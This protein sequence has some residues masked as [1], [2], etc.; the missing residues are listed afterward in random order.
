M[1]FYKENH[2][3]KK[4]KNVVFDLGGVLVGLDKQR[5]VDAFCKSGLDDIAYYVDEFRT[6]DLFHE[7]EIGNIDTNEFCNEVRKITKRDIGD[8]IICWAWNQLLTDI[9]QNKI[10]KLIELSEHY[11][12]FLLSNTNPIH[13]KKCLEDLFP[14]D[15]Y[16]VCDYFEHTFLSYQMHV[17]KPCDEIFEVMMGR[18]G[19]NPE[20]TLFLDD[21]K[22]NCDA[23]A[24]LKI[25]TYNV[26]AN[27]DWTAYIDKILDRYE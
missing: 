5:C 15:G 14:Y 11:R 25:K 4:L 19:I 17:V 18:G 20:E 27:S 10:K 9:K 22:A 8:D 26:V 2:M 7:L 6:E 16:G 12:L 3:Q 21:S 23:A 24:R 1:A 13:W